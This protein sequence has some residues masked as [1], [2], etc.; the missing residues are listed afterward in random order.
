MLLRSDPIHGIRKDTIFS[1]LFRSAL[2]RVADSPALLRKGLI[3]SY[4]G[5][6]YIFGIKVVY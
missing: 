6:K 4:L 5:L 3:H 2:R 1:A